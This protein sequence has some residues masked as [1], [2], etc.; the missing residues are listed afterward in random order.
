MTMD[1]IN[2]ASDTNTSSTTDKAKELVNK[3]TPTVKEAI[4]YAKEKPDMAA[5]M[6]LGVLNLFN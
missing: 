6:I 4:A 2:Q 5:L 1:N 3:A